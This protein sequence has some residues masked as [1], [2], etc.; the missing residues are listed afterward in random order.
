MPQNTLHGHGLGT[1]N[2]DVPE[3]SP[4]PEIGCTKGVAGKSALAPPLYSLRAHTAQPG[5]QQKHRRHYRAGGTKHIT[6][7]QAANII[8]AVGYAKQGGALLDASARCLLA[9]GVGAISLSA[10]DTLHLRA[11]M[12]AMTCQWTRVKELLSSCAV[13]RK[14]GNRYVRTGPS[15]GGPF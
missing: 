8:E 15:R 3:T 9:A 1:K 10:A 12:G 11:A 2:L 13:D 14:P 6:V 7:P 5:Q 4:D